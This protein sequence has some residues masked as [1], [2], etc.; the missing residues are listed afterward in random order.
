VDNLIGKLLS[1]FVNRGRGPEWNELF[2]F[3]NPASHPTIR[4]YLSSIREE[5]AQESKQ[6][7]SSGI[8]FL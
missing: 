7:T 3:G 8:I 6:E 5:Q 2:G 4:Q 1:L